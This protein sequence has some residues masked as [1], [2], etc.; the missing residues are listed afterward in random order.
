MSQPHTGH[1]AFTLIEMLVVISII[2]LLVAMLLPALNGARQIAYQA[3]CASNMR[4]WGLATANWAADRE[5]RLPGIGAE[6][7]QDGTWYWELLRVM[8][9]N[10]T[11]TFS[12]N[13]YKRAPTPGVY[14]CPADP[15]NIVKEIMIGWPQGYL[16]EIPIGTGVNDGW[17]RDALS[18]GA[19]MR[20]FRDRVGGTW[21]LDNYRLE[22][23]A[24]PSQQM[25]NYEVIFEIG[26]VGG[27]QHNLGRAG[28]AAGK[29]NARIAQRHLNE[30]TNT[31]FLDGH[32]EQTPWV[33]VVD[34]TD[35]LNI[36]RH[37]EDTGPMYSDPNDY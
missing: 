32:V 8:D 16:P 31:L 3:K 12:G 11:A 37:A 34:P 13:N 29:G 9:L 15:Y 10:A 36:W 23:F 14:T 19:N 18:Y 2:A 5:G 27:H 17:R 28:I 33:D 6:G 26:T 4:Q 1:R 35:P 7:G 22:H 21:Y 30:M 20:P 25:A 24:N